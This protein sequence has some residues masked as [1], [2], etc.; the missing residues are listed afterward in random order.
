M[1]SVVT[2]TMEIYTHTTIKRISEWIEIN[3]LLLGVCD[4]IKVNLN[5]I[6]HI[7]RE[8]PYTEDFNNNYVWLLNI[9]IKRTFKGKVICNRIPLTF[10]NLYECERNIGLLNSY[11]YA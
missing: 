9:H 11:I 4:V 3:R 1:L 8:G 7:S 5:N 2:H 10:T 6:T